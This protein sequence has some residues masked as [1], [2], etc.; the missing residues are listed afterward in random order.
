MTIEDIDYGYD[1]DDLIDYKVVQGY[2]EELQSK[3]G[4][5]S[6]LENLSDT[7]DSGMKNGA[8]S[9][10]ILIDNKPKLFNSAKTV[11]GQVDGEATELKNKCNTILWLTC[12]EQLDYLSALKN[13]INKR[14]TAVNTEIS[15]WEAIGN[16][17]DPDDPSTCIDKDGLV[18]S[19]GAKYH[20]SHVARTK[21]ALETERD[22]TLPEKLTRVNSKITEV[23]NAAP[24]GVAIGRKS[25]AHAP[26]SESS[27]TTTSTP[28]DGTP[29]DTS[30]DT[31]WK[32][33]FAD[34]K[35]YDSHVS[36][37]AFD[38]QGYYNLMNQKLPVLKEGETP[39]LTALPGEPA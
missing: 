23:L 25:Y 29:I 4:I 8:L 3:N 12:H 14:S 17:K 15:N 11:H 9:E 34:G 18:G 2:L 19:A 36:A 21:A 37:N 31:G 1:V 38:I 5:I 39:P 33:N 35:P 10:Q 28:Q 13:A 27:T 24:T 32:N 16:N 20:G 26:E 7:L 6:K 22:T 30:G